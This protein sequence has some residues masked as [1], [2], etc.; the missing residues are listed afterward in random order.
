MK[1]IALII[2]LL[3]CSLIYTQAKERV[4]E[5][6]PFITWSSCNIEIDKIVLSDTATVLQINAFYRPKYWIKIASG[7]F[8]RSNDGEKY[9]LRS[10]SGITPDKKFWMP[11]SGQASF[12][13]VFPPLPKGVTSIDFS[14]G[15]SDG[16]YQIFGIQLKGKKL[17][18]LRLPKEAIVHKI[19]KNTA[20]PTSE[21][22][23]GTALLKGRFLDYQLGII[24]ELEVRLFEPI[25]GFTEGVPVKVN[26]DGSFTMEA[27]VVGAT[28]ATFYA[29]DQPIKFF[30]APGQTSELIINSRELCRQ[31]SKL[32]KNE[33]ALG[34]AVYLNGP[35]ATIAQELN[36]SKLPATKINHGAI[37]KK[38]AN[39]DIN[40][41][42]AYIIDKHTNLQNK[43]EKLPNSMA[44]KQLLNVENDINAAQSLVLVSSILTKA[45][46]NSKEITK[47]QYS[48]F[49]AKIQRELPTDYFDTLQ[50]FKGINTPQALLSNNYIYLVY[51]LG[52]VKNQLPNILG[53][54]KGALFEVAA[55]ANIYKSL[56]AYTPLN[57][58]QRAILATLP[59]A[60]QSTIEEANKS[61]L[62]KIERNKKKTGF[63][64][65]ETGEVSNEDLFASIIA[66]FRGKVVLVDFWA[67]SC[68][69]CRS[70]NK[71]ITP[72]KEELK[73]K[74]IVYVYLTDESSPLKTWEN[75]IPHIHGEHFRVTNAQWDYLQSEF[76][77]RGVPT[78][79]IVDRSGNINFKTTGFC[80]VATMKRELLKALEKKR[81]QQEKEVIFDYYYTQPEYP[82]GM[83][84]LMHYLH[85]SIKYPPIAIKNNEEGQVVVLFVVEKDG[86]ISN[87]QIIKSVSPEIDAE[88]LRIISTFPKWTPAKDTNSGEPIAAKFIVPIRF[89]L[90]DKKDQTVEKSSKVFTTI[91]ELMEKRPQFPGGM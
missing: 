29:F 77:I 34:K 60:Y 32:R 81:V 54:D 64:I 24:T 3:L 33:K 85:K 23:S 22:T 78:Y 79:I 70:A 58:Q 68:G 59:A 17:P 80:G 48:I 66:K 31:Q 63:N 69:P 13:L 14:E 5:R 56:N 25:K 84:A 43:I 1:R 39:M 41:Y 21:T 26:A 71:A 87:P 62:T 9:T 44:I 11:K 28:F 73:D 76:K 86:T 12:Q 49:Y 74:D 65:N 45:K 15:D 6:P 38:V 89:K 82:G 52:L 42:K 61:L 35:L 90:T 7:S 30:L 53:T 36:N 27:T 37:I 4:I 51:I 20:L 83:K 8:L 2:S 46:L 16:A 10:S 18:S 40:A 50:Q 75:M 72:M 19:D 67:T 57:K 91:I 55:A 88:T 47:E